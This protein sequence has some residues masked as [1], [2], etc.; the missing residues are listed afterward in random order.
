MIR[1]I[2]VEREYGSQGAAYAH[3]LAR[4]LDWKLIDQCLIDEI[5]AKAGITKKL[6]ESCDERLDPWYYRFGKAFWHGSIERLPALDESSV[7]DAERMVKFVREYF[8]EQVKAGHC[9]IVGRGATAALLTMPGVFHVFVH[10]SM[11]RKVAWF[12]ENFPDHADE[13][14]QEILATDKRRAAYVRRFYDREWNDYRMYHLMLNSCMGFEAM[15]KATV[16]AAG[17]PSIVPAHAVQV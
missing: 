6:A 9:V 17:L 1:V 14:E 3:H 10:A 4:Y 12:R 16:E 11:K 15:V 5:A 8:Q 13:A 7:F 2:T